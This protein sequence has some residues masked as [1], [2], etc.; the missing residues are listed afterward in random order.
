M[1][2]RFQNAESREA[3]AKVD[4]TVVA[5]RA[6]IEAADA[7]GKTG[8]LFP[9]DLFLGLESARAVRRTVRGWLTLIMQDPRSHEDLEHDPE[10]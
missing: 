10:A 9:A 4:D 3:A 7:D 6:A 5:L 1:G 8:L 2:F